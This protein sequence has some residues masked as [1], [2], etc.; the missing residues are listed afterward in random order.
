L[1]KKLSDDQAAKM[2]RHTA[3]PPMERMKK[4]Q[5]GLKDMS[6]GLA[7]DPY[8]REFKF[9]VEGNL[10]KV[11]AR[12]LDPPDLHYRKPQVRDKETVQVRDGKW[13]ISRRNLHFI[14]AKELKAWGLLDL[15]GCRENEKQ[16]FVNALYEEG[17]KRS[18]SDILRNTL[19]IHRRSRPV[20]T[21]S[22][23]LF[24]NVVDLR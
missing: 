14:D 4:I 8:A 10:E 11:P 6:N 16:D 9:Q 18:I 7:N 3:V 13:D 20:L 21:L 17:S 1:N 15:S 24:Q 22:V 19:T 12:V 23:L 2:I 5:E